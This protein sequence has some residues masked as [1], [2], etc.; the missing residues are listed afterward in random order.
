M[1]LHVFINFM[2]NLS[3]INHNEQRITQDNSIKISRRGFMIGFGL[4]M[5]GVP[6]IACALG[7][8][9]EISEEC[10]KEATS[11][12]RRTMNQYISYMSSKG[13]PESDIQTGI[14]QTCAQITSD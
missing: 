3:N 2:E 6:M 14:N 5:L 4:S 10:W 1:I 12:E 8:G 7:S 11:V 9:V 13:F